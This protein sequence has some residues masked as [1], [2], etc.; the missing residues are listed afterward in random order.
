[1]IRGAD[2]GRQMLPSTIRSGYL[3]KSRPERGPVV[4]ESL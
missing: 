3:G 1:L 4:P 2:L